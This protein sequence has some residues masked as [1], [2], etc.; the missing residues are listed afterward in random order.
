MAIFGKSR[1]IDIDIVANDRTSAVFSR[2]GTEAM[3]MAGKINSSINNMNSGLNRYNNAMS[4]LYRSTQIAMVG[5]G[6]LIYNFTKQSIKEFAEFE[7]QHGKTMGAIVNNYDKTAEAQKR[8]L[9]DSKQLK[10]ESIRL[11]TVGPDGKGS[12]TDP[13]GAATAQTALAKSGVPVDKINTIT[14]Q[15][16]KFAGGNDLPVETA[17]NYAVNL[18]NMF[19]VPMDKMGD[20]LD[21]VTRAADLSTVD[22]P[23]IFESMKYAGE[24]GSSLKRSMEEVLGMIVVLGNSGLKGSQAGTGIQAFMTRLLTGVGVS[25]KKQ[26]ESAPTERVKNRATDMIKDVVDEK[27]NFKSMPDITQKLNDAMSDLNDQEQA[28]FAYKLFGLYQMKAGYKLANNSGATLQ[29]IISN[30][31]DNAPGTND[32]KWDLMLQTSYGRQQAF[33]NMVDGTQTDVGDRL[34]PFTNSIMEELFKALSSKGNYNIDFSKLKSSLNEASK[35]IEEQY[36]KRIGDFVKSLGNLALDGS[37]VAGATAPVMEGGATALMQLLGGDVTGAFNTMK[38]SVADANENIDKLPPELQ[39]MAR[40]TKNAMLALMTL[41]GINFGAKLLESI[42]TIWKYTVGKIITSNMTVTAGTVILKDTGVVNKDGKPIYKQDTVTTKEGGNGTGGTGGTGGAAVPSTGNKQII[43]DSNGKKI[44]NTE[45]GSTIV[46]SRGEEIKSNTAKSQPIVNSSGEPVKNNTGDNKSSPPA[47]GAGNIGG[48]LNKASWVYAI[49]EMFGLNNKLLDSTGATEGTK[50]R[51]YVDKGRTGLNYALMASFAD[52]ILLKGAGKNLIGKG[53]SYGVNGASKL[54]PAV[55]GLQGTA[56]LSGASI[57]VIGAAIAT[58]LYEKNKNDKYAQNMENYKNANASG[59]PVY[60]DD[61]GEQVY[62]RTKEEQKKWENDSQYTFGGNYGAQITESAPNKWLHPIKYGDWEKR[63]KELNAKTKS[64]E[65]VWN[66]ASDESQRYTGQKLK[67]D[68]YSKNKES[69]QSAYDNKDE[70]WDKITSKL[71]ATFDVAKSTKPKDDGAY[72]LAKSVSQIMD[73]KSIGANDYLN[74]KESWQS[75]FK[76]QSDVLTKIADEVKTQ[77][78]DGTYTDE[79][80]KSQ[81][82]EYANSVSKQYTGKELSKDDYNA[83]SGQWEAI[84]QN[85]LKLLEDTNKTIDG[86]STNNNTVNKGIADSLSTL[87]GKIMVNGKVTDGERDNE[88]WKFAQNVSQSNGK[89]EISFDDFNKQK[90]EWTNLFIQQCDTLA[91]SVGSVSKTLNDLNNNIVPANNKPLVD[92]TNGG[93]PL[94]FQYNPLGFL[95]GQGK[96]DGTTSDMYNAIIGVKDAQAPISSTLST[97]N[98]GVAKNTDVVNGLNSIS[99]SVS[100]LANQPPPVVNV[101]P[102]NVNVSVSVDKSGNVTKETSFIPSDNLSAFDTALGREKL[103][104]SK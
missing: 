102:P 6:Y 31:K 76:S 37:R 27:G 45:P 92:N 94:P 10:A 85:Q 11:G 40:E 2:V 66:F 19:N 24:M 9:S 69:W 104:F 38:K 86:M 36:G 17:T 22:V 21:M 47:T 8:F 59:I 43:V 29:D 48:M 101:A 72:E 95:N 25:N 81:S 70:S 82:Y 5:A 64:E 68:D 42:S 28:W 41:A 87:A 18:A 63:Q 74:G 80:K 96:G 60:F 99:S 12:L 49:G 20:M 62:G 26:L 33:K 52:S 4:G 61:K 3:G 44:N 46:N 100:A 55:A 39:G 90:D 93:I 56:T 35:L 65:N 91:T 58:I 79:T 1:Q 84:L 103:R 34:S 67:W 51:E 75:L 89:G 98:D 97:I 73:G 50:T 83:N 71:L 77:K 32:K 13:T 53:I 7:K 88:V 14:P 57:P 15:I 54:T 30:V 23:D 78:A 16:I